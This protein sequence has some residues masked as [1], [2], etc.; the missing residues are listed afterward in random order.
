MMMV[1]LNDGHW[2]GKVGKQQ[3]DLGSF[4]SLQASHTNQ[5]HIPLFLFPLCYGETES[6]CETCLV[7]C[8]SD[9]FVFKPRHC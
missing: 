5:L 7:C 4:L 9:V 2:P 1:Q 6:L 3:P 8:A